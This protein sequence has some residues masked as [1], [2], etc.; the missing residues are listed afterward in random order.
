MRCTHTG[1]L[2]TCTD[3]ADVHSYKDWNCWSSNF[4]FVHAHC[5]NVSGMSWIWCTLFSNSKYIFQLVAP[6]RM[7]SYLK[8]YALTIPFL[9]WSV[10]NFLLEGLLLSLCT[11]QETGQYAGK[12][13]CHSSM[14]LS[15]GIKSTLQQ[16]NIYSTCT[17]KHGLYGHELKVQS[18]RK[19]PLLLAT[20]CSC[21][22]ASWSEETK[23]ETSCVAWMA[24]S[25]TA[26]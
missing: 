21:K 9:Q 17:V 11:L 7:Q 3:S 5:R 13:L 22:K 18:A 10:E 15:V 24:A 23:V 25:M 26:L 19:K 2:T 14:R 8:C 6:S 12:K 1:D 4:N 20:I 16:Q